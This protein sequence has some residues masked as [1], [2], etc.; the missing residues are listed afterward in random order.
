MAIAKRHSWGA[1]TV[2]PDV[3]WL[4]ARLAVIGG[5]IGV[6]WAWIVLDHRTPE[7]DQ[8][9][10][11]DNALHLAQTLR[12]S[13]FGAFLGQLWTLDPS[14]PPL[15][16]A[17]LVPFLLFFGDAAENGLLVS[18][19]LYPLLLWSV[20]EVAMRLHG[21]RA[22][23]LASVLA[24]TM[25]LMVGLS[26]EV[27][28][29]FELTTAVALTIAL[30]LRANHFAAW[31][32]ALTVGIVVGLGSWTKATYLPF[33]LLPV[34]AVTF[35]SVRIIRREA[36]AANTRRSAI[37]R[38]RNMVLAYA[39]G[40]LLVAVWYVP[41]AAATL[42]YLKSA[43]GGALAIGTGPSNPI[44]LH[45]LGAF[46]LSVLTSAVG[47]PVAAV[48]AIAL[49]VAAA[50]AVARRSRPLA[51]LSTASGGGLAVTLWAVV[52]FLTVAT[53]HNQDIRLMAP[54][55]PAVAILVA[56]L[57]MSIPFDVVRWLM[58]SC[59]CLCGVSLTIG[60]TWPYQ[61][62]GL[63]AQIAISTP[64]GWAY[65]PISTPA[66]LGYER[67]PQATDYMAPVMAYLESVSRGV[68][69]GPAVVCILETDPDINLNTLTYLRDA[70]GDRYLLEQ[71]LYSGSAAE[72]HTALMACNVAVFVPP[73][74]ANLG[75]GGRAD[76]L[77]A[78][79]AQT[80]MTAG[81]L[82]LFSGP[83]RRF[84]I[85]FGEHVE[86]LTRIAP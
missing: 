64:V 86:I 71:V 44:T 37:A 80:H 69:P 53:A 24:A 14:H 9:Y 49:L 42:A 61:V 83:S 29:D 82:A 45:N 15:Y 39:I 85:D 57:V 55:L 31:R 81:D 17:S 50:T 23:I 32:S 76:L 5:A 35:A 84:P 4:L 10:Y 34:V 51:V 30:L 47:L 62:P 72:L 75:E 18:L 2:S 56:V 77:N 74:A 48:G 13:G 19:L 40:G 67:P 25:P 38:V 7:W 1:R 16:E 33:V 63:P 27:L 58:V 78:G 11:L 60:M 68:T 52:P 36:R 43:T 8:S 65:Y 21:K 46:T 26:R 6:T 54:A 28:E 59:V 3:A 22:A 41:H 70:R 66:M 12:G 73:S 20:A 79:F